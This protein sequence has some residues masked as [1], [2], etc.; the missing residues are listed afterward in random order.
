MNFNMKLS[1]V[2][3]TPSPKKRKNT[4]CSPW[5]VGVQTPREAS[6][7]VEKF[8]AE[9]TK[10]SSEESSSE[11]EEEYFEDKLK[12]YGIE[13]DMNTEKLIPMKRKRKI[14]EKTLPTDGKSSQ[15]DVKSK[16]NKLSSDS[17]K[18]HYKDEEER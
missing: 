2:K 4:Q 7:K 13:C 8:T 9:P 18:S 14:K 12:K 11:S 16:T 6:P 1:S 15:T 5:T 17:I 3:K 10:Q